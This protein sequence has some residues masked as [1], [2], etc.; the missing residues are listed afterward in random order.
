MYIFQSIFTYTL[1]PFPCK[2]IHTLKISRQRHIENYGIPNTYSDSQIQII[3]EAI[4]ILHPLLVVV[5]S[6]SSGVKQ[7]NSFVVQLA[8]GILSNRSAVDH[9]TH[10]LNDLYSNLGD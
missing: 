4:L 1:Q 10:I 7:D 8:R 5:V 6:D 2:Y 3:T 9:S